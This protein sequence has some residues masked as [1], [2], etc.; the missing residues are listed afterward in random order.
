VSRVGNQ[1]TFEDE[2]PSPLTPKP[3]TKGTITLGDA[4]GKLQ[5]FLDVVNGEL[6]IVCDG[7]QLNPIGKITIEQ[8]SQGGEINVK[9]AGN[10]TIEASAPGK[11][12]LKGGTGV[13]IDG[14]AANVEVKGTAGV[15]VDGGAGLV[16]LSG[17]MV[18]LN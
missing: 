15:K 3:A 17:S 4:D 16:E 7:G 14:G 1:L 11:L 12:T 6:R 13:V 5:L 10:V 8:K 18:K 9:S 2:I